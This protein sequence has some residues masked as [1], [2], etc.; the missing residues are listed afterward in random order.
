MQNN[1][2]LQLYKI[3]QVL[4][5]VHHNLDKPL[6]VDAL[7]KHSGLSRWQFN[8]IFTQQTGL[9]LG[10]YVRELRLSQAAE[11]LL[12]SR[13]SII[14][15]ALACGFNCN[16]SFSRSFKQRYDCAP[17]KYRQRGLPYLLKTPIPCLPDQLPPESLRSRIP[18][19]WFDSRPAFTVAGIAGQ[20]NGLFSKH[21][22]FNKKLPNLWRQ[23][24]RTQNK[25]PEHSR[26][27]VLD[28]AGSSDATFTYFAGTEVQDIPEKDTLSYITVPGQNYVVIA[29]CGPLASMADVLQWFF[30]IWLPDS[31][32]EVLD[33]YDL[34]VYP[35]GLNPS[36]PQVSM[37]YWIP[38][39]LCRPIISWNAPNC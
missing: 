16:V 9:S 11:M 27:G 34:E 21:P 20:V 14:D 5:H 26:I 30:Q 15:I 1:H 10:R 4:D 31:G 38:V 18:G 8:R 23:F 35:P 24:S 28:I 2:R 37:E 25:N 39:K 6:A 12:F 17:V 3:Q 32:C 36:A 29:F 19:I 7:A 13:R 33:G 22:D